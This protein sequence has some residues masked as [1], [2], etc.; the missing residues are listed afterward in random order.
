MQ[1]GFQYSIMYRKTEKLPT[2]HY[3]CL[4]SWLV[5]IR[6]V[7]QARKIITNLSLK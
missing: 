7:K 4:G 1:S 5:K 6:Y 2:F 3:S